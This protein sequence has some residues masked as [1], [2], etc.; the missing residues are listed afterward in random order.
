[1]FSCRNTQVASFASWNRICASGNAKSFPQHT[2]TSGLIISNCLLRKA[3]S[4]TACFR[5]SAA[6]AELPPA[7]FFRLTKA[8]DLHASP[9]LSSRLASLK[10]GRL[11]KCRI[12]YAHCPISGQNSAFASIRRSGLFAPGRSLY[13]CDPRL[14]SLSRNRILIGALLQK[15]SLTTPSRQKRLFGNGI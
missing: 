13:T 3:V 7:I 15:S 1:M 10:L 5:T 9:A 14:R 4:R 2:T 12:P 6:E 11:C 8:T